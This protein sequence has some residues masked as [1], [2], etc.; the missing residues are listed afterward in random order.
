MGKYDARHL[1][2]VQHKDHGNRT[3]DQFLRSPE[4]NLL[5]AIQKNPDFKA[6][7]AIRKKAAKIYELLQSKGGIMSQEFGQDGLDRV[8]AA[9]GQDRLIRLFQPVV[10]S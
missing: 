9:L 2:I 5:S 1:K 3:P 10:R 8:L 7:E 4:S 6:L